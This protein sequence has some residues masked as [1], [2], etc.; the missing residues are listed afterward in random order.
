MTLTPAFFQEMRRALHLIDAGEPISKI[1]ASIKSEPHYKA[2]AARRRA[3]RRRIDGSQARPAIAVQ[4]TIAKV[5]QQVAE[6]ALEDGASGEGG[7]A[8]NL[9]QVVAVEPAGEVSVSEGKETTE[10]EVKAET[11]GEAEAEEGP[12]ASVGA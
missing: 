3:E 6:L 11:E 9:D 8:G 4:P 7:D 1:C 2:L 10:G 5:V 12:P